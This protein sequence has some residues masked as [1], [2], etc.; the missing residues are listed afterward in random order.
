MSS[1]RGVRTESGAS[2]GANAG[3]STGG[4]SRSLDRLSW[5][6]RATLWVL[7]GVVLGLLAAPLLRSTIQDVRSGSPTPRG[8]VAE[9]DLKPAAL[10]ASAFG[11]LPSALPDF[12]QAVQDA[13]LLPGV[14]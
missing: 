1:W 11:H 2:A 6:G 12:Q 5:R 4:I 14:M 7:L 9:T 8:A 3:A 13:S 10:P